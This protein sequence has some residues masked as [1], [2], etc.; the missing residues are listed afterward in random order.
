VLVWD[1]G[2]ALATT[3]ASASATSAEAASD[4]LPRKI[5]PRTG[6]A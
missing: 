2:P 4:V 6:G 3:G 1:L 5:L